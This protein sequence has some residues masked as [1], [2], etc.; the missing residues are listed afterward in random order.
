MSFSLFLGSFPFLTV[1]LISGSKTPES[2]F[3][4]LDEFMGERM[5]PYKTPCDADSERVSVIDFSAAHGINPEFLFLIGLSDTSFPS[6]LPLDPVLKPREKAEINRVLKKRVFDEEGLHYEKEKHLFS[7]LGASASE[8]VFFSRFR[9]D[10]GSREIPP[11]D[12]LEEM[13]ISPATQRSGIFPEPEGVFSRE[14][15]LFHCFSPRG[16]G[17][18]DPEMVEMLSRHYGSDIVA[19]ISGGISAERKRLEIEGDY[20]DFEG[21]LQNAPSHPD[22]FS[23]HKA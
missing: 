7:T 9:H 6:A 22:T 19:H 2:I 21:V 1:S 16:A 5:I 14:D 15:A 12:F 17:N 18:G 3:F 8:K 4:L 10:Q 11:S 20:T 23:P 13:G